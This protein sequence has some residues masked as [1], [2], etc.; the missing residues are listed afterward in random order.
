MI[1]EYITKIEYSRMRNSWT[2]IGDGTGDFAQ[3]QA[4]T[5]QNCLIDYI[6]DCEEQIKLAKQYLEE[7]YNVV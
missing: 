3:Y 6:S 5:T 1:E 7:R 2:F 4:D